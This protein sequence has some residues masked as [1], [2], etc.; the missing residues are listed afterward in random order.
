MRK[1]TFPAKLWR[2]VEFQARQLAF[3]FGY[4]ARDVVEAI[5]PAVI[6]ARKW[7][8]DTFK[9]QRTCVKQQQ[10]PLFLTTI[11]APSKSPALRLV[12]G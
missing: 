3:D 5:R 8:W 7:F 1:S 6:A 11:I 2:S 4:V 9:P 10:L 12:H